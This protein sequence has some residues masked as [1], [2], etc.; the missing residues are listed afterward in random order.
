MYITILKISVYYQNYNI[1]H[2]IAIVFHYILT[3][4]SLYYH[5]IIAILSL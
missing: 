2:V 3:I 4:L 1:I 5:Y